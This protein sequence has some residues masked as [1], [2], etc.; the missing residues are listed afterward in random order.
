MHSENRR[1]GRL[2]REERQRTCIL[3]MVEFVDF[4]EEDAK[5]M[6]VL[7]EKRLNVVFSAKLIEAIVI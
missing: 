4:T 6:H 2:R 3:K 1:I 5:R 7:R